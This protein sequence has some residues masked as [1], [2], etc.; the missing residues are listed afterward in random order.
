MRD[1]I[2]IAQ[3]SAL[4]VHTEY[5]RVF[6]STQQVATVLIKSVIE[7]NA[8]RKSRVNK[9]NYFDGLSRL[10]VGPARKNINTSCLYPRPKATN[11]LFINHRRFTD[12]A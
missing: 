2:N 11:L 9:R 4:N 6:S 1:D 5:Q 7:L 3:K 10:H 8:T 12:R